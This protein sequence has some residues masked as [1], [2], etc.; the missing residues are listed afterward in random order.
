MSRCLSIVG[1]AR[2]VAA[3]T[4]AELHIPDP[5][6]QSGRPAIDGHVEVTV[7]TLQ[8]CPRFTATLAENVQIGPSPQWMQRR[9][10][11][12]GMRPINNVVDISNYVMLEWGGPNHIFDADRVTDG[13]LVV[14]PAHSDEQLTTLDGKEHTL[15]PERLLVCDPERALS[16][17]GV[18][19]GLDSEVSDTTTRVL[20]EVAVWEPTNIRRT[21][22]TLKMRSE[23][24]Y[25][26]ER[27][28]DIESPPVV[29]R[30]CLQLLQELAGA[31]VYAGM[32][33][34]YPEPWQPL[35][36]KLSTR[37]VRRLL[38]IRLTVERIAELLAPLGFNPEIVGGSTDINQGYQTEPSVRV[39]VPSWRRDVQY[40]ADLVE[41]VA[42]LH[43][44]ERIPPT[45]MADELPYPDTHPEL[46][47][48]Q[49]TR[50]LLV[51]S[52]LDEAITYPLTNMEAVAR[53][54]PSAADPSQYLRLA[55]PA[56]PEREYMRHSVL[57][58]LL[59]SL[60]LNLRERERTMLFEIGRAYLPVPGEVLPNEQPCLGIVMAGPRE[61][62]SWQTDGS[63]QPLDFFDLKG[64]VETLLVR[65]GINNG[66]TFV[67]LT[68]DERF[69]PGRAARLERSTRKKLNDSDGAQSL[70]VLGELHPA[71]RERLE[72]DAPRVAAAELDLK[73]LFA[74]AT[75]PHYHAISRFPATLQDLAIIAGVDVSAS[76]I[77]DVIERAA[78]E[79]LESL[80]LFDVYE[81]PQLGAGKRSLA[82]RLSFR[83]LDRTLSD[84]ALVK[85]RAKIIKALERELGATI[86]S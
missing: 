40:L 48:E 69:H 28:V 12:A 43:G 42:R 83:A 64:V 57:T 71:V 56:T 63:R 84:D 5:Q 19:G 21:A 34:V 17:A 66:I 4:G 37:E 86:R 81:G 67:P 36:L 47:L 75:Q 2:E 70:G 11:Y 79:M 6:V 68:D 27:G 8:L 77:A 30:R 9:L 53:L 10:R 7:E 22:Q 55:N 32:I 76:R 16:L 41:D 35:E 60:A 38:G 49:Q 24:S 13:H 20:V 54:Q 46:V 51:G 44:Y 29:Q 31:T 73:A 25:R 33:D 1:T 82:Y 61:Q 26:F 72:L 18:M 52:G 74:L 58:T 65:L 39:R 62:L 78:G 80:T 23:A 3:L 14:R 50:N 59:E 85:V 45:M 15:T